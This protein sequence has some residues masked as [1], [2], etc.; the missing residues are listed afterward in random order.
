MNRTKLLLVAA[1]AL[2]TALPLS[3]QNS[4][5]AAKNQPAAVTTTQ[6]DRQYW[7]E[8]AARIATP[9]LE[10]MSRGELMSTMEVE[11]SPTWGNSERKVAYLECFGRLMDG[12]A[13]WLAL[14]DDRT[15][16]GQL[17]SRLRDMALK[18]YA[19]AVDPASADYLLWRTQSQPLVDAAYL[20]SSFMRAREALWEPLDSLTKR[21][22]VEEFTLLRRVDPPYSN[23]LLF[24]A[25]VE[26]FLLSIG[27]QCD[28]FRIHIALNK[29]DEWYVGDGWYSDG[30]RF[31]F[32]YYNSFVIHPMYVGVIDQII[33]SNT[34]VNGHSQAALK[35]EFETAEKRMQRFGVIL[36]R[37]IAP[38]GTFPLVGR[39]MTYRLAVFQPL[40][41]LALNDRLPAQLTYGQVRS[42]LTATIKRLF[43]VDGNFDEK[44]FLT[45]G[46]AGHQPE[47]ADS[48]SNNGSMYITSEIFMPLGLAA[49][50]PFWTAPAERW[51]QLRGWNGEQIAK[52]RSQY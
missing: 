31:A 25:T 9:V 22:Y 16:E 10:A 18:S 19:N 8:M 48:Y 33:K 14:P 37:F 35:S 4:K 40:A 44:G 5:R 52:D 12:I 13:P 20:A 42:A 2:L 50:H 23:W 3:S 6:S 17:R 43:S 21:R 36:E 41:M 28:R 46:F 32:D 34:W 49:D 47:M 39:S 15:A 26:T 51:T 7:V 24:S 11:V 45:I 1:V 38:D 27:E 30:E 29:V